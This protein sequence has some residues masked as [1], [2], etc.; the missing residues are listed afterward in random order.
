MAK[1]FLKQKAIK[2]RLLGYSYSQ[3]R[4]E[5]GISKS[6][7]SDWL[8]NMPL[9]PEQI[10]KLRSD[11]D[12][13]IERCRITKQGNKKERLNLFYQQIAKELGELSNRELYLAGLFLYW[14][15]GGK[16][17]STVSLSNT[18]PRIMSFFIYWLKML[19]VTQK[20]MTIVLQLY[21][22]MNEQNEKLFW[23]KTLGLP[24]ENFRKTMF[25]KSTLIGLSYRNGFGHG[26][27]MVRVFRTALFEKI[28]LSFKYFGNRYSMSTPLDS[29]QDIS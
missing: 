21:A 28:M 19:G 11:N 27:C 26:T 25:K 16:T 22:D 5:S 24:F 9:S 23:S 20:E 7:L 1:R 15:E 8:K 4:R 17:G 6:T 12:V 13:R 18:D 14:G 29:N 10:K 2:L 3:I